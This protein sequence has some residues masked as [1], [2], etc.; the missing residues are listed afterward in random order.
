MSQQ[1][2][3][4]PGHTEA[5]LAALMMELE[6]ETMAAKSNANIGIIEYKYC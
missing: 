4:G 1:G 3:L 5:E 2:G 6:T